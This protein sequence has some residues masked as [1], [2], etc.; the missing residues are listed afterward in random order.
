MAI[1]KRKKI[2]AYWLSLYIFA[3]IIL[4]LGAAAL[5]MGFIPAN[6]GLNKTVRLN[7]G[8]KITGEAP[9]SIRVSSSG[10]SAI[11]REESSYG[12][13]NRIYSA[14]APQ[15]KEKFDGLL[16]E[17]KNMTDF[18]VLRGVIEGVGAPNALYD[19]AIQKTDFNN[20]SSSGEEYFIVILYE[21]TQTMAL[22]DD[23]EDKVKIT[24]KFDRVALSISN[25]NVI[26][27][28]DITAYAYL[29]EEY[30]SAQSTPPINRVKLTGNQKSLYNYCYYDLF[31]NL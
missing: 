19:K 29:Q 15:D 9:V 21:G 31:G 26:T 25:T 13:N 27:K 6:G 24:F 18:S 1:N 12:G 23:G 22:K 4:A 17:Y 5:I 8:V 16:K 28:H 30:D 3:G 11:L 10:F 7:G 20:K 14:N 2:G